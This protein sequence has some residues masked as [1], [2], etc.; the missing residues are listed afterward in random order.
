MKGNIR[1][2]I[3]GCGFWGMGCEQFVHEKAL[4]KGV[5][6]IADGVDVGESLIK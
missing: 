2:M 1:Y 3:M 4:C 5:A 6:F